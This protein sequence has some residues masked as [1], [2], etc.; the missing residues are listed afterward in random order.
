MD[1][2]VQLPCTTAGHDSILVV[3]DRLSKLVHL[4]PT[5]TE[6]TALDVAKLFIK[7]VVKHHGL[8]SCIVSDRDSK[9]TSHFW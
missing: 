5:T 7:E 9:F 4:I 1:F 6:A 8:P 2:I 3:I